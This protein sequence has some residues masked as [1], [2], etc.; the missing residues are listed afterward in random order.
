MN[1]G[2]QTIPFAPSS[3][4][5]LPIPRPGF[6]LDRFEVYNWGTFHEHV[7]GLNLH[8]DNALLTG[9]IGSG[10]STL[11]DA[12]TTLLVPTQRITYNKA[13]GADARERT[14]RT[15]VF[16]HYKSERGESG[17]AAKPIALRGPNSYSV[18]LGRFFNEEL[19]QQVTLAQLFWCKDPQGQPARLYLVADAPISIAEHFTGFGPD[20]DRLR[21]RLRGIPTVEV[22]DSFPPYGA[23]YR[24]RFGID[25]EQALELFA[26]TVS[27]KSV[28]NL[29][30]FVREHM[31]EAFPVEPRITALINHFDDLNRA[32]EAVIKA[33]R[34]IELL[35]P[36][37][38]DS[39]RH[40]ALL[41][42]VEQLRQCREALRPWFATLKGTLLEKRLDRLAADLERLAV[43]I[44]A[45][46]EQRSAQHTK[47]DELKQAIA[48]NGGD[49]V[50]RLRKEIAEKEH[51]QER[52]KQQAAKYD[53]VV[54]AVSLP[55]ATDADVFLANRNAVT[56]EREGAEARLADTQ[57][58]LNETSFEFRQL[59]TQHDEL[60]AEIESLRRR[61]SNIPKHILSIRE[62]LCDALSL[63]A[64][65]V[66]FVGELLQVHPEARD[67]EGAIE[68]LLHNFGVSL[69]VPDADYTRVAA[70]VDRTHLGGRVVYY[71]VLERSAAGRRELHPQSL[72]HKVAINSKS[73]FYHWLDRELVHRFD[74]AC[75]RTLD[76]FRREQRAITPAG[77]I[78]GG[79]ERH[80]KDDRHRLDDRTQYVLGWSN[81]EKIAALQGE[82]RTLEVQMQAVGARIAALDAECKGLRE[83]LEALQ[84]LLIFDSFR[85]LDWRAI[86]VDI[87]HLDRERRQLE[88]ASDLLRTLEAQLIELERTIA[89]TEHALSEQTREQGSVEHKRVQASSALDECQGIIAATSETVRA[90]DFPQLEV[91]R[92][93]ALGD[94]TLTVESCD[95]NQQ[96]MRDWVQAK[97]E[98]QGKKGERLRDNIINAMR[99]YK[100]A[101]TLDTQEVDVAI[102]AASEYRAMLDGLVSDDLPRFESRFK[103]LL[104]E[105]T[106]REVANFQSH[107]SRERQTIVE[108]IERINQSLHDIDYNPGRYIHLNADSSSDPELRDFQQDLR[109]CTEGTLTGSEDDAYSEAKFLQVKRIIERFR[110]REG[111]T[112]LDRR[113]TRKVTDVR[114]WYTFSASEQ[115]REDGSEYEHYT[116]SGGKSGGQKEKLAYTV[117]AA[118]LA[119]QF[120]LES[121]ADRPRSFRFVV[122]D[123]AFG[124][125]SDESARYGLEL[126]RRLQLQLLVVTPLQKIHIIEPYVA[127]VGFV[128]NQEGRLSMLRNLTIEEYRA[129]R[130]AHSA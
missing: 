51:E 123:E 101:Y 121:G 31:L 124:R 34:Q 50:E 81:E 89:Q 16:G 82:T 122:I 104:N 120:G 5:T 57:N 85:D 71:R 127:G 27:M 79:N 30:E 87:E 129:E 102:E 8:G 10:K 25:T 58:T 29:T 75:C 18:I 52:R 60:S 109:A 119:Y 72:V 61:R 98:A 126:F 94:H 3:A 90:R 36:L 115:W 110:G 32:H 80:E 26:Q 117:L 45:I 15:Y 41:V 65:E 44:R 84:Q 1:D 55:T 92:P 106:I 66:P 13:A 96:T 54:R 33:K 113:W 67:W 14:L 2:E 28:G 12:I 4:G 23:A 21:K 49:R 99:A 111:S 46:T 48:E 100:D 56:A 108:R 47:R 62:R 68:R 9:D 103:E 105:N 76:D 74:Y 83:R 70:W 73:P 64:D 42:H 59:K 107:L 93:E 114:N 37:V 20:I 40:A 112:E 19:G 11:V 91:M 7:W 125:G 88:A 53:A 97:I 69:L 63:R 38:A 17:L 77:Q 78:K 128:Y 118:S 43:R 130:A 22:H 24:R 95:N 6:R 116:D 35:T 86:A 39:E